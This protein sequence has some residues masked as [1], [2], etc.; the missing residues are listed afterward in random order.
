MPRPHVISMSQE[1]LAKQV[2]LA[3]PTGKR[4]RGQPKTMWCDYISDLAWSRP[5]AESA[6]LLEIA[7]N[8][9]AFGDLLRN[10]GL[11]Q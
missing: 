3:T 8:L 4:P 1:R 10:L 7:E 9:E 11:L 6:E 5:G 2:L